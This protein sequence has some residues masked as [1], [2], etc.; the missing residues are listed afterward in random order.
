MVFWQDYSSNQNYSPQTSYAAASLFSNPN[1]IPSETDMK[2]INSHQFALAAK[3]T[4]GQQSY[5]TAYMDPSSMNTP[6]QCGSHPPTKK[7]PRPVPEEEKTNA[8]RD[9][10]NKNNESAKKSREARRQKEKQKD[11]MINMLKQQVLQLQQQLMQ[12]QNY[13]HLMMSSMSSTSTNSSPPQ[14]Y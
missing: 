12:I 9:R 2:N 3:M 8:Y 11:D 5:P 4:F 13:Q 14:M 7:K 1:F 10:R 6:P